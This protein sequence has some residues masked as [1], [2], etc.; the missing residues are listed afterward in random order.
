[1][2]EGGYVYSEP[3]VYEDVALIDVASMHPTSIENLNLF[4]KYTKNF[5]DL[6]S[7]RVAI[8]RGEFDRAREMLG[9]RLRPYLGDASE[10]K[11]LSNA[12]KL[13]I[14][15]VYGFTSATF[16][17]TFLDKR[18][19]DNIVAKRGALFMIDLKHYVQEQG[20]IVAHI[21][22]DSI[23]I[24]NAS[25]D[26]IEKVMEFG[27][28]YGYEFEH[29]ATYDRMALVDRAQYIA[30]DEEG[31]HATGK[32]FLRPYVLKKLF[33][34]EDFEPKD[35]AVDFQVKTSLWLDFNEDLPEGEHDRH[36]IGRVGNFYPVV[37]GRGGA[38]L[39]RQDKEDPE[40]F[41]Y[42]T[43]AKDQR[44]LET[45]VVDMMDRDDII[46]TAYHER[47]AEEARKA[48]EELPGFNKFGKF[49]VFNGELPF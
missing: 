35:F 46:D 4:G 28:K 11:A 17:N 47:F 10:A 44:W 42:A 9:G 19:V 48:V 27:K 24:P 25:P 18:N 20:Y 38:E 39:L 1:M 33:T 41:H 45:E 32:L 23:K 29:E 14:N 21:K 2:G 43:G 36:H 37:D 26:I 40:K 5:S 34:K 30:H 13:V 8:K 16:D 49:E 22:T 15:K 7:A 12:L 3:G 6:K 31:W